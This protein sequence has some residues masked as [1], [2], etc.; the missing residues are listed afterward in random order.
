MTKNE[1]VVE[2]SEEL[3]YGRGDIR[4]ML[5]LLAEIAVDEIEQGNDFVV[6]GVVRL[7]YRYTKPRRK[8]DKYTGFGGE[9]VVAKEA[10]PARVR[11]SV[12][13]VKDIKVVAATDTKSKAGKAVAKAK[14]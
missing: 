2:M 3:G 1:L 11:L 5:D 8:G 7:T 9:E 4:S 13:A 6:P 12:N 14:G 10:R